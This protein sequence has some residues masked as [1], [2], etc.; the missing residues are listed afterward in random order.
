MCNPNAVLGMV[1]HRTYVDSC[2]KFFIAVLLH[3]ILWDL[4]RFAPSIALICLWLLKQPPGCFACLTLTNR[5]S[6]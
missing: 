6:K 3:C 4:A 1:L 5:F 2:A